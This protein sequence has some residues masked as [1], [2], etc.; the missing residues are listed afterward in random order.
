MEHHSQHGTTL[1]GEILAL[2]TLAGV[3]Q[4]DEMEREFNPLCPEEKLG[5][6]ISTQVQN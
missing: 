6:R 3:L 4:L 1:L 5:T 2:L